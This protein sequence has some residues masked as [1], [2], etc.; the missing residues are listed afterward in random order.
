M[1]ERD[2]RDVQVGSKSFASSEPGR[3]FVRRRGS[4]PNWQRRHES[5]LQYILKKPASLNAEVAIHTGYSVTHISR[6]T[7][8][9]EFSHRLRCGM[10]EAAVLA[11]L[12]CKL[13]Q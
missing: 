13:H 4:Y 1:A 7:R 6:I 12:A 8:A 3:P 2:T 5:V 9:P 10:K 11:R